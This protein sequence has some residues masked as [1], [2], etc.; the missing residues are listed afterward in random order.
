MTFRGFARRGIVR[1]L[2]PGIGRRRQNAGPVFGLVKPFPGGILG[3]EQR[4]VRMSAETGSGP[5][6][7][8]ESLVLS[9]T[10]S[11]TVCQRFLGVAKNA[12]PVS[13][14]AKPFPGGNLGREQRQVASPKSGHR[15]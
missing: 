14:L 1:S 4:Q 11:S 2:P 10:D 12:G 3:R 7:L 13:G 9:L 5:K 8:R 6:R 15:G